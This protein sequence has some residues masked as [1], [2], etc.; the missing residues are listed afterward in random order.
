MG[1]AIYSAYL[2][3]K[4]SMIANTI[5]YK[6]SEERFLVVPN[7]ANTDRVYKWIMD[8]RKTYNVRVTN[9][10][11]KLACISLQGPLSPKFIEKVVPEAKVQK[12]V[13]SNLN[14]WVPFLLRSQR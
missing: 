13:N 11:D 4:G 6:R 1:E 14:L 8:N 3:N 9:L 12:E 5:I 10:S 7:A 2:N